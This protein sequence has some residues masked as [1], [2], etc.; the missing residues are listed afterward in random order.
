MSS[1]V[2]KYLLLVPSAY[3]CYCIYEDYQY[4]NNKVALEKAQESE[5]IKSLTTR[6]SNCKSSL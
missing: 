6:F 3:I 2:T 1:S 5:S 4:Q